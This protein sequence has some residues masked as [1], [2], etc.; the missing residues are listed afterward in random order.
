LLLQPARQCPERRF[1]IGGAQYPQDFPWSANVDFVRHLPPE[2]HPGFY[3][4]SR[5]TLNVTRA[6]MA[7]MGWCPSGRLFEASACGTALLSDRWEG[8]DRFFTPGAEILVANSADD[9]VSAIESGDAELARIAQAGRE[10]TLAQH[11]SERRAG[12]LIAALEAAR[13]RRPAPQFAEA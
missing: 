9:A 8:L 1:L 2:E 4:S 6:A 10:R 3:S 7:R 11:T 12:E 5:L 13:A